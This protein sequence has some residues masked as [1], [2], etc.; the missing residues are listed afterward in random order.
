MVFLTDTVGNAEIHD[1]TPLALWIICY[2][3]AA[4]LK[5]SKKL[6]VTKSRNPLILLEPGSGLEPPTY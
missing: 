6:W 3:I 5:Y 2:Q 4:I 1:L